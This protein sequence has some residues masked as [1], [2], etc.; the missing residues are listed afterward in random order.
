MKKTFKVKILTV[1]IISLILFNS[2]ST[3]I[4]KSKEYSKNG[5]KDSGYWTVNNTIYINDLNPNF[6]WS[7]TAEDNYWCAGGG[8]WSNPYRIE[9]VTIDGLLTG[10]CIYIENSEVPFIIRNCTLVNIG[11]AAAQEDSGIRL[12]NVS[13]GKILNN[14][15]S[16][17]TYKGIYFKDCSNLTISNNIVNNNGHVGFYV[18]TSNNNTIEGNEVINNS[19]SIYIYEGNN[20]SFIG[21][22]II[23]PKFSIYDDIDRAIE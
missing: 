23:Q 18:Y 1:I 5:L 4:I 17:N 11:R 8:T 6:N 22:T 21:N 3:F 13:N 20:N 19:P 12:N 14:T 15:C 7:K 9:N 2:T 10:S 16:S